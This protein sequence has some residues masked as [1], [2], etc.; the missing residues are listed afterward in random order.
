MSSIRTDWATPRQLF[1]MLDR[2]FHFTLDVCATA[3]TAKC[4]KFI[5]EGALDRLEGLA[6]G[7]GISKR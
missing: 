6:T 7:K 3:E 5:S 1:E 4:E 2:E